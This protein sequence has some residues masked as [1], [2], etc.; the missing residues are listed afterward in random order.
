[1]LRTSSIT[2]LASCIVLGLVNERNKLHP[3]ISDMKGCNLLYVLIKARR[4]CDSSHSCLLQVAPLTQALVLI[5]LF[6]RCQAAL[7][8]AAL[9]QEV[10]EAEIRASCDLMGI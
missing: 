8:L 9:L 10:R 2:E 1:M 5:R 7:N 6:N 3:P 4:W